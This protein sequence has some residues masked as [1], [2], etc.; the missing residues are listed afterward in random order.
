MNT[1]LVFRLH[2]DWTVNNVKQHIRIWIL[3][4]PSG[5][6]TLSVNSNVFVLA[7]CIRLWEFGISCDFPSG[8]LRVRL[9]VPSVYGC[10]VSTLLKLLQI[11]T[12][13]TSETSQSTCPF[14]HSLPLHQ[15]PAHHWAWYYFLESAHEIP[16]LSWH[17]GAIHNTEKDSTQ[18][19]S[20]H[21]DTFHH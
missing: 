13:S 6:L 17:H 3:P 9:P 7:H 12:T 19:Q 16:P 1:C 10:A 4:N 14:I 11:T 2:Y 8:V 18:T 20:P 21:T 15:Q 5:K